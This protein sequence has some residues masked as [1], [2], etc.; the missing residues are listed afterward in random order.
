MAQERYG[1]FG[2]TFNHLGIREVLKALTNFHPRVLSG[3]VPSVSNPAWV[4]RFS[5][6]VGYAITEKGILI[7]FNEVEEMTFTT[8]VA[9]S[10]HTICL[11]HSVDVVLGGAPAIVR[12]EDGIHDTVANCVVLGWIDYVGGA[13]P[14]SNDQILPAIPFLD[15]PLSAKEMD[16]EYPFW[17]WEGPHAD[18]VDDPGNHANLTRTMGLEDTD[19]IGFSIPTTKVINT[20]GA[21]D[22]QWTAY[23]AIRTPAKAGLPVPPAKIRAKLMSST[24]GDFTMQFANDFANA[25]FTWTVDPGDENTWLDFEG[26]LP[27]VIRPDYGEPARLRLQFTIPSGGAESINIG[28]IKVLTRPLLYAE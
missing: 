14:L 23:A 26:D 28:A 4:D 8:G 19:A 7:R 13:L 22:R 27:V 2:D 11:E 17:L 3:L 16:T 18:W 21:V 25:T 6:S 15:S 1:E 24:A 9:A 5:I 20:D 10:Q 12:L